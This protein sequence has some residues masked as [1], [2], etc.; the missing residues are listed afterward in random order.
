MASAAETVELRA[1]DDVALSQ[2]MQD[3]HQALF[4][5]RFQAATQQL[6]DNSQIAKTRKR[7][8]RIRT[9]LTERD[10]L[11][12]A[13]ALVAAGQKYEPVP[14]DDSATDDSATDDSATDDSPAEDSA[15]ADDGNEE[16]EEDGDSE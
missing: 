1:M 3:A 7:I 14:V 5:L 9:L 8:A 12:D 10:I 4:N 11:A 15:V 2:E 16:D 13:D 6:A